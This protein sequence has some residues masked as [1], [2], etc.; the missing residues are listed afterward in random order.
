M[1]LIS[2]LGKDTLVEFLYRN[3]PSQEF[4]DYGSYIIPKILHEVN[5]IKRQFRGNYTVKNSN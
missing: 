4:M 3:F 5:Y 2:M 1:R